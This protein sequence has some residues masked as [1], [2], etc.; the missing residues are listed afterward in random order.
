VVINFDFPRNAETYLHR[1]GRSG[2]FGHLGV[3]I[4]LITYEDRENL[5]RIEKELN[6]EIKPIPKEVDKRLYVAEF[7]QGNA[8]EIQAAVAAD[9]AAA[10]LR[11][12]LDLGDAENSGP[13]GGAGPAG[14][15]HQQDQVGRQ[16][17]GVQHEP[18]RSAVVNQARPVAPFVTPGSNVNAFR[19]TAVLANLQQAAKR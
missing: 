16:P 2:R 7:Q 8:N 13:H 1:I 17:A 19:P 10:L 11:Q 9:E 18:P 14:G 15:N 6:T 3:A 5:H 12:Q 4:N